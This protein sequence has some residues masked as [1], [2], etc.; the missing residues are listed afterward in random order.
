[1]KRP[2][3][4]RNPRQEAPIKILI[5]DNHAV[6]TDALRVLLDT[7]GDM[8]V[9]AC[10]NDGA[11]AVHLASRLHPDVAVLGINAPGINGIDAARQIRK[12]APATR[13]VIL[14]MYASPEYVYQAFRAGADGYVTKEA[15]A[16]EL[17]EAVRRVSKGK[18]FMS[19]AISSVLIGDIAGERSAAQ[20]PLQ[21]LTERE[22]EVLRLTVS[23]KSSAAAAN[24]LGLSPKTVE[25]YRSRIM[26]KLEI[27]DMP[28]LVKFAIRYGLTS[29]E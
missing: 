6:L 20:G 18:R 1:M 2:P 17:L 25:S 28:A 4:G 3:A 14:S 27:H 8:K 22:H 10:A 24:T 29:L 23:G 13:V 15:G 5:A 12:L 7:Q 11:D 19:E 16:A 21:N 9:V 26:R